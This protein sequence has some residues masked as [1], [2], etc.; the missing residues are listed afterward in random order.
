MLD[1]TKTNTD[2]FEPDPSINIEPSAFR[3][4]SFS[5]RPIAVTPEPAAIDEEEDS[6]ML[7]DI[8]F[9]TFSFLFSLLSYISLYLFVVSMNG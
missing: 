3:D 2:I 4:D 5:V 1:N 8:R 9:G 7:T 6:T